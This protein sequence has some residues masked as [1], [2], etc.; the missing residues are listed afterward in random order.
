MGVVMDRARLVLMIVC[1]LWPVL[2]PAIEKAVADSSSP[3]DDWVVELLDKAI[4][5]VCG[6]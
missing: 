2:K 6:E 5:G 1:S 3:I 4:S